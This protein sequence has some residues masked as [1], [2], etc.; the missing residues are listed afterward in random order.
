LAHLAEFRGKVS[1][2]LLPDEDV[3]SLTPT[4]RT[5]VRDGHAGRDFA[6]RAGELPPLNFDFFTVL[7]PSLG[8]SEAA[9]FL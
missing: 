7:A 4:S 5:R 8:P 9:I 1:V 6:E 2:F 3:A